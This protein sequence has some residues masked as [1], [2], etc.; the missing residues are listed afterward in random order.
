MRTFGP[1]VM[2]IFFFVFELREQSA[3]NHSHDFACGISLRE[4]DV[5]FIG[6]SDLEITLNLSVAFSR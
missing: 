5:A 6:L 2:I 3:N 4:K 1:G